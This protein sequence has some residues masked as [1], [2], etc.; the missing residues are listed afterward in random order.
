ME[1]RG[2]AILPPIDVMLT[3]LPLLCSLI[4]G[5]TACVTLT[6]PKKLVSN[7]AFIYSIEVC[8]KAPTNAY[9]ALFTTTSIL[10]STFS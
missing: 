5:I 6:A 9:P 3:I 1:S 10:L 2:I 7:C 8:S 4:T